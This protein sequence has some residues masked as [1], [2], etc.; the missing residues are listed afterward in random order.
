MPTHVMK[1]SQFHPNYLTEMQEECL[2][3]KLYLTVTPW[4]IACQAPLS[5][6]FS[7]HEYWSWL[8]F[9]PLEDLPDPGIKLVSPALQVDTLLAE[10]SRKP[11]RRGRIPQGKH[12]ML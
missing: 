11:H 1:S 12:E 8:P 6:R 5:M 2:V 4:N 3:A 7:R 10:P 9:P